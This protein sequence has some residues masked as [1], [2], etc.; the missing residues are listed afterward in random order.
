MSNSF[1]LTNNYFV[2]KTTQQ[3]ADLQHLRQKTF[4]QELAVLYLTSLQAHTR[5]SNAKDET[6]KEV[7]WE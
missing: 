6:P 2:Q 4:F 3:I 1:F 7:W 5:L